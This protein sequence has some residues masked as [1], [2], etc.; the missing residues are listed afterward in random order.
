MSGSKKKGKRDNH[1]KERSHTKSHKAQH[2]KSYCCSRVSA[3]VRV[4]NSHTHQGTAVHVDVGANA[5]V[6]PVVVLQV[7]RLFGLGRHGTTTCV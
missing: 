2:N 5:E 1:I 6:T 3:V 7:D 4:S